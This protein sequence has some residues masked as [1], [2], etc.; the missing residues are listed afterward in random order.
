M[1]TLIF[2]VVVV[3]SMSDGYVFGVEAFDLHK[4]APLTESEC[5]RRN[6]M[7]IPQEVKIAELMI[8]PNG[9]ND[10]KRHRTSTQNV[11]AALDSNLSR[12]P[13]IL[14][15]ASST[16]SELSNDVASTTA[17]RTKRSSTQG[18]GRGGRVSTAQRT[19]R[20]Q[21]TSS[22]HGKTKHSTSNDSGNESD[23][24]SVVVTGRGARGRGHGV[25]GRGARG[26]GQGIE[27]RVAGGRGRGDGGRNVEVRGA[28]NESDDSSIVE[29][30][31]G[32]R[33]RGAGGRGA[34]GRGQGV[35]V[36][37]DGGRCVEGRGAGRQGVMGRQTGVGE[38][39]RAGGRANI[40]QDSNSGQENQPQ[41]RDNNNQQTIRDAMHKKLQAMQ[42]EEDMLNFTASVDTVREVF[43]DEMADD[44]EN[45]LR[46][47]DRTRKANEDAT[48]VRPN[49]TSIQNI[50][51]GAQLG[52][53]LAHTSRQ[54]NLENDMKSRRASISDV[55][56]SLGAETAD[57]YAKFL[58]EHVNNVQSDREGTRYGWKEYLR[59]NRPPPFEE[60]PTGYL[61][62]RSPV[63]QSHHCNYR[64][65][66]GEIDRDRDREQPRFSN[67][68]DRDYRHSS[69]EF[70]REQSRFSNGYNRDYRRPSNELDR[71]Q[72]R[73][74]NGYNRDYRRP[75]NEFDREQPRFSNG[76][77]RDYR[78]PSI[79]HAPPHQN[80]SLQHAQAI[81]LKSYSENMQAIARGSIGGYPP[82]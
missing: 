28:G 77:D 32:A 67:G 81:A 21:V 41:L 73:F 59:E 72:S 22:R 11:N 26:R 68:H 3:N 27:V 69:N 54:T 56:S 46:Q 70:D 48:R 58:G 17:Q 78:R 50:S 64:Q 16:L 15:T 49:Y 43:S 24:S 38:V 61:R 36:R 6:M 66:S 52:D 31:R 18:K 71:E 30:G 5:N 13:S 74:S 10:K 40:D 7:I 76:N 57:N 63:G 37:G 39:Q 44:Y 65:S 34:G 55:L 42:L 1:F 75:S 14:T 53:Q 29:T 12:R 62:N 47:I 33:G 20:A 4:V 80:S 45:V 79:E 25:E 82:R 23:D 8:R 60:R 2:A 9:T 19:V 51:A 35:E